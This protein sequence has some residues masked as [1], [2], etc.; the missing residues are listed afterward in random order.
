MSEV[1]RGDGLT[2]AT[3][4]HR[5][6]ARSVWKADPVVR[7]FYYAES[8]ALVAELVDGPAITE[9]LLYDGELLVTFDGRD[10]RACP[11][12]L[13]LGG[14]RRAPGSSAAAEARRLLGPEVW[15]VAELLDREDSQAE[16]PLTASGAARCMASWVDAAKQFLPSRAIGFELRPGLLRAVL[17]DATG[18]RLGQD[19]TT[20]TSME[21][22]AVVQAATELAATMRIRHARQLGGRRFVVGFQLGGPVRADG[23]VEYFHRPIRPDRDELPWPPNVPLA[24]L[25]ADALGV[26]V[27]VFNDVQA[28]AALERWHGGHQHDAQYV[29]LV[30]RRGI[31]GVVV[32]AGK[33]DQ[34]L[35]MEV[36]NLSYDGFA[37]GAH[38]ESVEA[39]GAGPAMVR[40]ACELTGTRVGSVEEAA[41]LADEPMVGEKAAFA[42]LDAGRALAKAVAAIQAVIRPRF[43]VLYLSD[44]LAD[45][46]R[47]AS[48]AYRTGLDDAQRL[49]TY[50]PLRKPFIEIRGITK[51]MGARG[52]ALIALERGNLG[53]PT[54]ARPS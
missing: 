52:A 49:V 46:T 50:D 15:A 5:R 23:T 45:D 41:R 42:F 22:G 40:K 17:V 11:T 53:R 28:F 25:L 39:H 54:A 32:T 9:E 10:D 30:V 51:D 14:F 18:S 43:Y 26:P 16:V 37:T 6:L 44:V 27:Y 38:S 21:P 19:E 7:L 1:E 24:A 29:V 34:Q 20:L 2:T 31:G 3:V 35:V 47:A 12:S 48:R 13:V 36:G 8:D 4:L 33:V